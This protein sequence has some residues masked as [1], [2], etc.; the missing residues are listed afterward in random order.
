[1]SPVP[2][3]PIP[4]EQW[5]V[6]VQKLTVQDRADICTGYQAGASIRELAYAYAVCART[7]RHHL[8]NAEVT[9]RPRGGHHR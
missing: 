6:R 1:M 2:Y 4:R 9:L 7:I 5:K 3:K 8:L